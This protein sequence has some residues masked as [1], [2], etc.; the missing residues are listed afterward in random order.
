MKNNTPIAVRPGPQVTTREVANSLSDL[1]PTSFLVIATMKRSTGA[2]TPEWHYT[3]P[4]HEIQ[5]LQ[6]LRKDKK[7]I[8]A[9]RA[10]EAEF[11]LLAKLA[12]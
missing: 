11:H 10:D 6:D 12:P 9:Q 7:V 3:I 1:S 2:K 4:V 5:V 8:T